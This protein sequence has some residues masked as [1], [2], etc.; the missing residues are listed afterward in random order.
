[1][2]I[3]QDALDAIGSETLEK[4]VEKARSEDRKTVR[5]EDV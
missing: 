4:A 3:T 2:R 1:M 5:S